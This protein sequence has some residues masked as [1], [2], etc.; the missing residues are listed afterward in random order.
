M[1]PDPT[2]VMDEL[3]QSPW[4]LPRPS[5]ADTIRHSDTERISASSARFLGKLTPNVST[6]TSPPGTSDQMETSH[7]GS[8]PEL[9]PDG[10]HP[11]PPVPTAVTPD[12][13]RP[14]AP[15]LRVTFADDPPVIASPRPSSRPD[16]TPPAPRVSFAD[17]Q[18][19]VA[20]L[21]VSTRLDV[22]HPLPPQPDGSIPPSVLTALLHT[23]I[24][25]RA[26]PLQPS[27]FHFEWSDDAAAH[28]LSVLDSYGYDLQLAIDAEPWSVLSPG[29]E[30]RPSTQL[31]S[32]LHSHPL[33][34]QAAEWLNTGVTFP[35]TPISETER[36]EDLTVMLARGNHQSAKQRSSTLETMLQS[37]VR[38][39][40]QLPLPPAA[41]HLIPGAVV[42]P[43]GLIEQAT[44]NELGEITDK[45]RLT[46]DQSFNPVK[47]TKRSVNNRVDQSQLTRCMF[48]H[49][50]VRHLHHI[51]ALR[52]RH[53]TEPILQSKVD[54]K[55]AYRRL[56]NAAS[57]AVGAM[58]VVG[59]RLLIAL[60]LT[61]GGAPNPSRWSD[62]SEISCDLA[63]D[64]SRHSGWD[65]T[66]HFSPH[67]A[68][69]PRQPEL[70]APD[71][72]FA[73]AEP[74]SVPLPHDDAP[75]AEV[76]IDDLFNSYLL[77]DIDRGSAILPFILFLLGRPTCPDDPI[78][79]D[80]VLSISKFL[81]EA[82]PSEVKTILGWVVDTRRMLLS[83]PAHKVKGWITSIQHMID[84]PTKV[85]HKSL[86]TLI[87]RLNHCGYLIPQARHFLGRLRTAKHYASKKRFITL[88]DSQLDDLRLWIHFLES[89]GR[90]IDFNLLTHR[91]PTHVSR[92]DACE[93]GIGGYSLITGKGWRFELP[94]HLRQRASLNA[95]EY[96]ATYIQIAMEAATTGL[97]PRS[98]ILTGTDST[99]AAGWLRHSGF[100]D[101][102]KSTDLLPLRI[103]RALATLLIDS[104][105][106]LYSKWFPGRENDV[107]DIL[108]RDHHLTNEQLVSLL[109]SH[110]P[111]QMPTDFAIVPLPLELC[112]QITTWL[113]KLPPSSQSPKVPTR[114]AAGTSVTTAPSSNGSSSP[115]T[116]SSLPSS[117]MN[118]PGSLAPSPTR[119]DS[120]DFPLLNRL[121]H[122]H[123][124][125]SAT[126][127]T[128]WLRP[129]G[130]TGI[131]A[132]STTETAT[133]RKFYQPNSKAIR[134]ATPPSDRKRPSPPASSKKC[135]KTKTAP[136]TSPTTNSAVA[137]SSSP[138]DPA[139]T[140]PS[141]V[142]S[143]AP[144]A[145]AA[146][147]SNSTGTRNG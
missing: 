77:R 17:A 124:A 5:L 29:C 108:S 100:D 47:R 19:P 138:C 9:A 4:L 21:R 89:A 51:A 103:S 91:H 104:K 62:L 119:I 127:S 14:R 94:V 93:H 130:I 96:M 128:L 76:Y 40:W 123:Q 71:V 72:P 112:S 133:S 113:L 24:T 86:E 20:S 13:A 31:G 10:L 23:A 38:H 35:T 8:P 55:S 49:S 16:F 80:D 46:H 107:A 27:A 50:L 66:V 114:S 85:S 7:R 122:E 65:E 63:N 2:S 143:A 68:L 82:T 67:A 3:A 39:G 36:K 56:H 25:W 118:A 69:L 15:T 137:P 111:E 101:D 110:C 78:E 33:W 98:V 44:I 95:L 12:T 34:P 92:V 125:L 22:K 97:P 70:E 79:R 45:L 81:A 1:D 32:I 116:P 11:N 61:F 126:P 90:G 115:T 30:F 106:T 73:T 59:S 48:G 41:A 28:N 52:Y 142:P 26:P 42:A 102:K 6:V 120:E 60:R 74:L 131:L 99:S 145:S 141:T 43:M 132:Q 58:V 139:N 140:P 87:G 88:T 109:S 136:S 37:E 146:A 64:L 53:P 135:A 105:A 144:S 84:N 117:L 57:T 83:L 75:K 121:I 147:T 129:T 54:W 134:T 18:P